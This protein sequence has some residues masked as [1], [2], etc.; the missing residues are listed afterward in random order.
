MDTFPKLLM[1]H[2]QARGDRPAIREKDLGI[3]QTWTWREFADEV[4]ALA[5]ALAAEGLKRGEHVAI[6]GDNRPR[7]YAAMSAA[8]CLGAIPVP[9]Y[10]DA[11]AAEMA[12]PIQNAEIAHALVED[13]EQ[14]DKLLEILPK[15]PSL[16]RIYYDD[17]RGMR[18]YTQP[19]LTSYDKLMEAGR[20]S[21]ARDPGFVDKEIQKGRGSDPAA[22]FFTSGTTGV[23]KGVV[24]THASLIGPSRTAAELEKLGEDDVILAYLPPAWIGQNIFS[25][26]QAFVTGYCIC[27]PEA[28]ETVMTDMREVG[29]TYYFAPPR[30]LEAL[31]TQVSIRMDD[32]SWLKRWLYRRF[33]SVADRVGGALLDGAPV[34][35]LDRLLYGL[36]DLLVYGPLRN[37]LGM[38]RVRVGYTAGEAIGPDLFKFYRS[39]GVNMKQLY[40]STETAVFV[41]IQPNG[42]VRSDTVG[43]A[44][45]G[46]ELK[47]SPKRELL[48]RSPGLF[49]EYYK[50]PQATADAK[51]AEGFFH[52]GDAGFF[53]A[54]GHVKIIDRVKDVGALAEGTLF[55]PKYLENKLKFFPYIK[56]A[57]CFGHARDKVCAF[58]NIDPEAIGNWAEK[59]NMPYSGYTDL[60]SRDE[61]YDLVRECIERVNADLSRETEIANSQIHRFLILHKELDA[62]DEELTRT[63][64]VRRGF[65]GEKYAALV[66][67]LYAGR[68]AVHV[69]A[70]VRYEDGRTGTFSADLKIRDAKTFAPA[71]AQR[72]A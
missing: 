72:A 26:A 4:R 31:L 43:P 71:A 8:Q 40:G 66:E 39:I 19:Q 11:V 10:Q 12:F 6:V 44:V 65:V 9:L 37:V 27:C 25:C 61:V 42:Q 68:Q 1:H 50:N 62:D 57:V 18:H 64:K 32:A 2:A 7:V 63:R 23:P 16:R 5:A 38:S 22:M 53:A 41:C 52:T 36:G 29:P 49:T 21:L 69:E 35:L 33:M 54:D 3:W 20:A 30:V 45:P 59:R 47:F 60:A 55:A 13:Q 48:I 34:S 70:K 14:V 28:P 56:E 17:P 51:D 15:C 46:V 24:H 58:I 67:A